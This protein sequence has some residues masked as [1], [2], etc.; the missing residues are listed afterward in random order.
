LF[1]LLPFSQDML[2]QCSEI[3]MYVVASLMSCCLLEF[4]DMLDYYWIA[5]WDMQVMQ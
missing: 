4:G 2:S 1:G 5:P 3:C